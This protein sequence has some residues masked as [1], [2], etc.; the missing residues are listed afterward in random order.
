M[1]IVS[2]YLCSKEGGYPITEFCDNA[3][4]EGQTECSLILRPT[5][6]RNIDLG[7]IVDCT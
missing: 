4:H 1:R 6:I 3:Q 5:T 7:T 2:N